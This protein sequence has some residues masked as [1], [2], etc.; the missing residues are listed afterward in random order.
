MADVPDSISLPDE[1]NIDDP[2]DFEVDV[3]LCKI[4]KK[5]PLYGK[6]MSDKVCQDVDTSGEINTTFSYIIYILIFLILFLVFIIVYFLFFEEPINS[7]GPTDW[8]DAFNIGDYY[9]PIRNGKYICYQPRTELVDMPMDN[10]YDFPVP[11]PPPPPTINY[12]PSLI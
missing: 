11:P 10:I 7:L 12:G 1:N 4:I 5:I 6:R 8:G 3:E 2:L 9:K